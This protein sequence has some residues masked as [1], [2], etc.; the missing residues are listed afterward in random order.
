MNRIVR[1]V[2]LAFGFLVLA[3]CGGP[4][5]VLVTEEKKV[6]VMPPEGLWVCPDKLPPPPTGDYKQDVV[7]DYLLKLYSEHKICQ[8]SLKDVRQ[9]LIDAKKIVEESN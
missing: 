8:K 6:L 7:A 4:D 3:G 1:N 9:F 2:L 5:K